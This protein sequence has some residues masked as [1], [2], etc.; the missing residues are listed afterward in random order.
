[1]DTGVPVGVALSNSKFKQGRDTP[2]DGSFVKRGIMKKIIVV[3]MALWLV[4]SCGGK[5]EE[6]KEQPK[7]TVAQAPQ[8]GQPVQ[9]IPEGE[10]TEYDKLVNGYIRPYFDAAGTQTEKTVKPGEPFDVY[11]VAEYSADFAMCAAEYRLVVPEGMSVVSSANCDSTIVTLGH[12]SDDFSI[13]FHCISGPKTWL[14]RYACTTDPSFK[15]GEIQT[16]KGTKMGFLGF[17]M[18]DGEFT[19]V[20]AS[21]GKATLKLE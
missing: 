15:G 14:V 1:V 20:A 21:P 13:T 6:P 7:Q 3:S 11:L 10:L 8:K 16:E 18:C 4:V 9:A 17:S 19:L 2:S 12:Y 5:K